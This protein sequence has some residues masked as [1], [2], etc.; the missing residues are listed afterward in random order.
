V[1]VWS[2]LI[3]IHFI[4]RRIDTWLSPPPPHTYYMQ[5]VRL[6]PST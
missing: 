2:F 5:I 6:S 1:D 3:Y 4:S